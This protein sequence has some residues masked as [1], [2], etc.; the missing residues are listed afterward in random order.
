MAYEFGR[1]QAS[2]Q[3]VIAHIRESYDL[4]I[5]DDAINSLAQV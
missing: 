3:H 2:N 5:K 4:I 1:F